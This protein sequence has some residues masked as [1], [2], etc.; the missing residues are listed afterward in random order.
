MCLC[1]LASTRVHKVTQSLYRHGHGYSLI[2]IYAQTLS[3]THSHIYLYTHIV[4]LTHVY[5]LTLNAHTQLHDYTDKLLCTHT[6]HK[7][8]TCTQV[9]TFTIHSYTHGCMHS[10]A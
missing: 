4:I 7:S 5:V 2:C 6:K 8:H 9:D 10:H 3:H 1:T